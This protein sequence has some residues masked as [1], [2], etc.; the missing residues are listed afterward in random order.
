MSARRLLLVVS[1]G[2]TDVQVVA[3]RGNGPARGEIAK[4]WA[5]DVHKRLLEACTLVDTPPAL[6]P[7]PAWRCPRPRWACLPKLDAGLDWCQR[8]RPGV[9]VSVLVLGTRRDLR[10]E[11]LAAIQLSCQRAAARGANPVAGVPYLGA[12]E[13]LED[14]SAP[15]DAVIRAAAVKRI[16]DAVKAAITDDVS[17]VLILATGG[18]PAVKQLLGSLVR[19]RAQSRKVIEL[20]VPRLR[21]GAPEVAREVAQAVQPTRSF[22]ARLA[23]LRL[24]RQGEW[25]AAYGATQDLEHA[26]DGW[27][28]ALHRLH[29]WSATLPLGQTACGDPE[30]FAHPLAA[31]RVA[32]RAE[33]ALRSGRVPEALHATVGFVEEALLDALRRAGATP[34][35]NGG[36]WRLA[37]APDAAYIETDPKAWRTSP[38][39]FMA[40]GT[41]HRFGCLGDK[42]RLAA[43]WADAQLRTRAFTTLAEAVLRRNPDRHARDLRNDVAHGSPTEWIMHDATAHMQSVGL[44]NDPQGRPSLLWPEGPACAV[45]QALGEEAGHALFDNLCADLERTL[46]RHEY[47]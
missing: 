47:R 44:W 1:T 18:F 17:E 30:V 45:L 15:R 6:L 33:A 2:D 29:L 24:V 46:T 26:H 8:E 3:D 12:R 9:P 31:V 11:P 27:A 34:G 5:A 42:L 10:E 41:D 35:E 37:A 25:S 22:D 40:D 19:F 4:K 13:R 21:P 23:A 32:L 7:A 16:D 36:F 20:A 28:S 14:T 38:R 43:S 39:P